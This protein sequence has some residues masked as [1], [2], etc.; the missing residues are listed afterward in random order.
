MPKLLLKF[1]AA[2]IKEIPITQEVMTVGRKPDNDVVIDNP[3][4][5]SHHCKIF[6]Q[7]D[8]YFVEDLDS[9]NGT[10][11]NDKRV[12]KGGLHHNDVVGL[13][14]KHA[15]VFVEDVPPPPPAAPPAAENPAA[16]KTMI[17]SPKQQE[18]AVKAAAAS[19]EQKKELL[20]GLRILKGVVDQVEYELKGMSTYI[21]K[22][23]RVQIPIK[24]TGLFGS[25][26]EVA[27]SVHRKPEGYFLVAVKDGYPVVNGSSVSGQILL[28][29]GDII[30]CGNTTMQF[31]LKEG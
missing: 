11:I 9:T 5:S 13:A 2:V 7:A 18:D 23:D 29:D 12:M 14:T 31:Y 24:G 6:R 8:A 3:A 15:L 17:L 4:V 21:G 27:A 1:N 28:K 30:E 20:G 26:P 16:E 25:A 19:G 10:Y 22:S